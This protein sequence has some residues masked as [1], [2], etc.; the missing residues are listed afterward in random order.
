MIELKTYNR[1][2]LQEFVESGNFCKFDFL[3]ITKHR[4]LSQ[5][6]NPKAEEHDVL[7]TLAFEEG[8]LAGYLGSLPDFFIIEDEKIKFAWLST[9]YVSEKFRGKKIAQQLLNKVFQE[10]EGCIAM[11]EFTKEAESLYNKIGVF[12]YIPAKV[13]KRYY[14]LSY[15]QQQIPE[16]Y[17]KSKALKPFLKLLDFG[18][19]SFI[20]L[21]NR[22]I[23]KPK[24]R[25]EV[26]DFI[27]E[28]SSKFLEGFPKNRNA[29]EMN[30]FVQNPWVLEGKFVEKNY[31]FS[32]FSEKFRY[33]WVKIFD[34]QNCIET[35][36]LL[37]QR[38]GHLK[39][40]YLFDKNNSKK[41]AEFLRYFINENQ[42]LFLTNY[43][44][45]LGETVKSQQLGNF[46]EKDFERR[47]LFHKNLIQ[48]LPKNF[49]PK[50]QDGDG[51]CAL[52]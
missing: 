18:F 26:L 9:L 24:F 27:N 45:N 17:P 49:N 13:G 25:F 6:K 30:W 19:N 37:L 34:D 14:F 22:S 11:T 48:K 12:E 50:F 44:T 46:Y 7:L 40:P 28:E 21:K 31:L 16:K 32:S 29:E 33:R 42:I 15:F 43:Q 2:Q 38:D 41:F 23:M 39:I 35:V 52:T 36:A 3:P 20:S 10:Y 47:Y 8:K 4:A 5:I 1:S 51:D